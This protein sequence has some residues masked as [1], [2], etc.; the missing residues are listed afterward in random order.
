MRRSYEERLI[1]RLFSVAPI[2][3]EPLLKRPA[4]CFARGDVPFTRRG[5]KR[6][7]RITATMPPLAAAMSTSVA[8]RSTSI[9]RASAVECSPS[10]W[11]SI[12]RWRR[13]GS[14]AGPTISVRHCMR[15]SPTAFAS[16]AG[17]S[18]E[19]PFPTPASKRQAATPT[20]TIPARFGQRGIFSRERQS[21]QSGAGSLPTAVAATAN[22]RLQSPTIDSAPRLA[23][24]SRSK[25]LQ[26]DRG[27]HSKRSGRP[28]KICIQ[29]GVFDQHKHS[30]KD[31]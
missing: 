5:R 12:K 18:I 8:K 24:L 7:D 10:C 15:P 27:L 6:A 25:V 30:F 3:K 16:L 17:F 1:G 13:R 19:R 2:R 9:S 20:T 28:R 29:E 23:N 4:C 14:T 31:S 22:G 21:R 26:N 11:R